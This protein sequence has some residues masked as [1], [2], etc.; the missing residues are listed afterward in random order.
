[1]TSIYSSA[2]APWIEGFVAEKR[3]CGYKYEMEEYWLRQ[4]D[5]YW[6]ECVGESCQFT[7]EVFESWMQQ[8][9]TEGKGQQHSRIS[10]LKQLAIY[11]TGMGI[12]CWIPDWDVRPQKAK[13]HVLTEP[14]VH[15]L[16]KVIDQDAA[17]A[18]SSDRQLKE[19]YAVM[20]RLLLSTGLRRSEA[21]RL[22]LEDIDLETGRLT[23]WDGKGHKDR[24]LYTAPDMT[25]CLRDYVDLTRV[26]GPSEWLFPRKNL[27]LPIDGRRVSESFTSAWNRTPCAAKVEK[28]PTAHSLRHTYTV[29]RVNRWVQGGRDVQAMMPYL[30]RH[31][32]H[33]SPEQTYYYFHTIYDGLENIRSHDSAFAS[34]FPEVRPK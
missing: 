12:E 17:A 11:L 32:G 28:A 5:T 8:R 29:F 30:S 7:R 16:F 34:V 13:V 24:V 4:F 22:R 10:L 15:E 18:G 6:R 19:E 14:E 23:V 25:A 27:R 9:P 3:A 26:Y 21:C 1:M 33:K 31:L 20:F 2:I